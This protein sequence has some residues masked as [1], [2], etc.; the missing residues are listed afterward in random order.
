MSDGYENEEFERIS[1]NG[2]QNNELDDQGDASGDS[3][4]MRFSI[5]IHSIKEHNFKG[6]LFAKYGALPSL[7]N[8]S[9]C[10]V[11]IFN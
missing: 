5:D 3:H 4:K 1:D 2:A 9:P 10:E 8:Q 7:G 6:L 11:V